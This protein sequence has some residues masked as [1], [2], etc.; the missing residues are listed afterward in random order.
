MD[1][2]CGTAQTTGIKGMCRGWS[3]P[4]NQFTWDSLAPAIDETTADIEIIFGSQIPSY[5][6]TD[7]GNENETYDATGKSTEEMGDDACQI[8]TDAYNELCSGTADNEASATALYKL[9]DLLPKL[10][11]QADPT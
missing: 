11:A 2:V 6:P 5:T 3:G 4:V 9:K 7:A 10:H 8:A 1:R